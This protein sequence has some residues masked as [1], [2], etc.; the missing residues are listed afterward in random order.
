MA[1]RTAFKGPASE[2]VRAMGEF[3]HAVPGRVTCRRSAL[4]GAK[5][6]WKRV[7]KVLSISSLNR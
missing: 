7:K 3:L 6:P 4:L 2:W 5:T 1:E